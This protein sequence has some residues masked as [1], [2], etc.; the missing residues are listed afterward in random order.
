MSLVAELER[1][2]SR[3]P[4][5]LPRPIAEAVALSTLALGA[6]AR[7]PKRYAAARRIRGLAAASTFGTT[8]LRLD[9]G[10][11]FELP[12]RVAIGRSVTLYA[13]SHFVTGV[14]G[15]LSIGDRTHIG[16]HSVVS[17]LGGVEIGSDC[18]ISSGFVVYSQTNTEQPN[19]VGLVLD[20]P[21]RMAKVTLGRDVLVGANV[22]IL[23]GVTVGDHAVLGA[24]S[25]VTR[26]VPEWTIVAGVPARPLR[27]R[28]EASGSAKQAPPPLKA[29]S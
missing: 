8:G 18:A 9:R 17:A 19:P 24:G 5:G 12:E 15:S 7:W 20:N 14:G 16:R 21:P 10:V 25:V 27:D 6:L 26:D 13:D 22:T 23:P 4:I 2:W 29:A 11:H 3:S 28:R 1:L